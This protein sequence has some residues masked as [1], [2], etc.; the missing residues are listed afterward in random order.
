M[1]LRNDDLLVSSK[2]KIEDRKEKKEDRREELMYYCCVDQ[3]IRRKWWIRW[4]G[5]RDA[6]VHVWSPS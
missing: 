5:L 2:G 1:E 4:N 3:G 6:H